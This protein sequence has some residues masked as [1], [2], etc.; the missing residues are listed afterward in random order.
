MRRIAKQP[1]NGDTRLQSRFQRQPAQVAKT[2]PLRAF[3]FREKE[4]KSKI[5]RTDGEF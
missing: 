2:P 1:M 3:T 5:V 4:V